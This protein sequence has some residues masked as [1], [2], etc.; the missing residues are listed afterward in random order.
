MM[1]LRLVGRLVNGLGGWR[2]G[3][4]GSPMRRTCKA[5]EQVQAAP[6]RRQVRRA[7]CGRGRENTRV[8]PCGRALAAAVSQPPAVLYCTVL[9][10]MARARAAAWGGRSRMMMG[11]GGRMMN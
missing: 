10:K 6:R 3:G 1:P 7:A 5:P 9:P 4:M 8:G 2:V 11:G